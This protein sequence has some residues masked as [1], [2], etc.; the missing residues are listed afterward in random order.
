MYFESL[1]AALAMDG[2]G[3][4]VWSAYLSTIL[5][6]ALV[7]RAPLRQQGRLLRELRAQQR[8]EESAASARAEGA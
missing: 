4:Y 6:L 8:R 5:I 7:L 2:H 1:H 3:P